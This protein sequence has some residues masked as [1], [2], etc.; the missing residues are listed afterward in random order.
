[1]ERKRER[2]K[3]QNGKMITSKLFVFTRFARNPREIIPNKN[4]MPRDRCVLTKEIIDEIIYQKKEKRKK[5]YEKK[6]L[7][8]E[9]K[10]KIKVEKSIVVNFMT[11][12]AV[13]RGAFKRKKIKKLFFKLFKNFVRYNVIKRYILW[14]YFSYPKHFTTVF[15]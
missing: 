12:V 14:I 15:P 5:L 7:I 4:S 3:K 10:V 8:N 13:V 1:M 6:K 2:K 11:C 9:I